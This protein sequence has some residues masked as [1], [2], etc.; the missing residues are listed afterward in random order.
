M[1]R[2][3][4]QI[5]ADAVDSINK[6]SLVGRSRRVSFMDVGASGAE[7]FV[8]MQGF[9]SMS[10]SKSPNEYS[11]RY[12]DEDTE[13]SDVTGYATGQAFSFD[14]YSPYTVHQ[15][16]AEIVDGEKLGSDTHVTIV[17]VDL[18]SEGEAKTARKRTYSVV[19]DS[20]GD[21]TDALIYSGTFKA[22]SDTEVGTATSVDGWKTAVYKAPSD[23]VI[24][25]SK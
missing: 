5:F 10:E 14:R 25:A 16:L 15:K 2:L 22:V 4:L 8:R 13:R 24:P 6:A 20:V 18:F 9:T 23:L 11:R 12:V 1:K 19:P 21:G 17:T 7:K 3:N